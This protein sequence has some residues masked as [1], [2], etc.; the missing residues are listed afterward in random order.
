MIR[1]AGFQ[2]GIHVVGAREE[3]HPGAGV[4]VPPGGEIGLE[5][6]PLDSCVDEAPAGD[7]YRGEVGYCCF[8]GCR[9]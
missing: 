1:D 9:G 4:C 6:V 2:P 5:V 3:G 8:D 7:C